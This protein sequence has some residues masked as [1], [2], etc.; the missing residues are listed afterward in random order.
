MVSLNDSCCLSSLGRKLKRGDTREDGY[1]FMS[2]QNKKNVN[3]LPV[4]YEKWLSPEAYENDCRKRLEYAKEQ[5]YKKRNNPEY[6]KQKKDYWNRPEVQARKKQYNDNRVNTPDK[7]KRR[8]EYCRKLAKQRKQNPV[9]KLKTSIRSLIS[10]KFTRKGFKKNNKAEIILG[11]SFSFFKSYIE[12]R[13][14]DGMTWDN[15]GE[16]HFDHI[17]PLAIARTEKKVMQLNHYTNF[18]PMRAS[19]NMKKS[20]KMPSE[21][22]ALI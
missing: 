14:Q 22:L 7:R 4:V 21:Q 6:V 8:N 1:R 17:I 13:F 10:K 5:Y 12:A 19:D 2:Y 20:N 3:G 9:V 11:C 16:W 18:R 15:Y